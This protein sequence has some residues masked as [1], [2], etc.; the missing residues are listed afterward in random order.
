MFKPDK[1]RSSIDV[2]FTGATG[3][4]RVDLVCKTERFIKTAAVS[5][6]AAAR[7]KRLK[8]L[9]DFFAQPPCA[10]TIPEIPN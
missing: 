8:S 10:L 5:E 9:R 6:D 1:G 2:P 3:I 4:G 7:A